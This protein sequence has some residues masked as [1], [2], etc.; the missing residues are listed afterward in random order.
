MLFYIMRMA[1]YHDLLSNDTM[2]N[3]DISDGNMLF[4]QVCPTSVVLNDYDVISMIYY[5]S[6]RH[7]RF[8]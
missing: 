3:M 8:R 1:S 5:I 6:V 7:F 4:I 2:F